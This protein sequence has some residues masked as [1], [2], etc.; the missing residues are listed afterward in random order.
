MK[1][2]I[3]VYFLLAGL[4]GFLFL[5]FASHLV[6]AQDISDRSDFDPHTGSGTRA[7]ISSNGFL[8]MTDPVNCST[9]PSPIIGYEISRGQN[10]ND[11]L[12]F[13]TE[14]NTQGFAVGTVNISSG[15]IPPCVDVLIVASLANNFPLD[16]AYTVAEANQL[17]TWVTA[18]H[19]LLLLSDWGFLKHQTLPLF[20]AFG[21]T[22]QGDDTAVVSD[23]DD[24]DPQGPGTTWVIYQADNFAPH[25]ILATMNQVEFLRSAWLAP[26]AQAVITTDANATPGME[27]VAAAFNLGAGCAVLAGDSNWLMNFDNGYL[28]QANRPTGLMIADWLVD[29]NLLTIQKTATPNPVHSGQPLTFV[30]TATNYLTETLTNVVISDTI[31]AQTTFVAASIPHTGPDSNGVVN[32]PIGSLAP[33]ASTSITLVVQVAGTFQGTILNVAQVYSQ[34][35]YADEAQVTVLV[36]PEPT[37]TP[38]PT[39]TPTQT[40]TATATPTHTATATS[41]PTRT[42]TPTATLTHTTTATASPTQTPTATPTHTP[43]PT[44]TPT[45]T[46]TPTL[47]STPTATRTATATP[48]PANTATWTA[49][50]TPSPSST[51]TPTTTTT[52]T[53]PPT[54]SEPHRFFLPLLRNLA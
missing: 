18:G 41:T 28:K 51:L 53:T 14:L 38:A 37:A 4:S 5:L 24:F 6:K 45:T 13:L 50:P 23:P 19:G 11:M 33:G 21:Y 2:N 43:T 48:T 25:P 32:W 44:A 20:Q 16:S 42:P 31:P 26:L 22:P 30:M 7:R 9:M 8:P 3:T 40:P 27:P 54:P 39:H 52:P 17:Q 34:E 36:V 12:N 15:T 10:A 47:T 46:S 29:C 49:T 1:K 35:G